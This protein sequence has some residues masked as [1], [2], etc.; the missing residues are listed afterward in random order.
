M[1]LGDKVT[2]KKS[3]PKK[4]I[5]P[6]KVQWSPDQQSLHD[7]TSANYWQL[8]RQLN[9]LEQRF[10]VLEDHLLHSQP[11]DSSEDEAI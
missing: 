10:T 8:Q 11:E 2:E 5:T 7:T 1:N 4:R 6:N 3:T 9:A